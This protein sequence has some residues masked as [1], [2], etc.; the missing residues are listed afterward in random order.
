[1]FLDLFVNRDESSEDDHG[2]LVAMKHIPYLPNGRKHMFTIDYDPSL[3]RDLVDLK[4]LTVMVTSSEGIHESDLNPKNHIKVL[5]FAGENPIS[6]G[7]GG[8]CDAGMGAIALLAIFGA[9]AFAWSGWRK[10]K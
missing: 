5:T 9:G 7:S 2:S 6:S 3:H 4:T 1:V 8:G 10:Q